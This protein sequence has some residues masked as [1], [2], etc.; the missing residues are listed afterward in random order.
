MLTHELQRE[1]V[2]HS[3][4]RSTGAEHIQLLCLCSRKSFIAS[5]DEMK[6]IPTKPQYS[7]TLLAG[8]PVASY[9]ILGEIPYMVPLGLFS[10]FLI[11]TNRTQ[12]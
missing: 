7:A 3:P 10:P 4:R 6:C 9:W 5:F 12:E 2:V 8:L 11:S 1:E